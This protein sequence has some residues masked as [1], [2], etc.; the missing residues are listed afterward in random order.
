MTQEA[1]EKSAAVP[2]AP[3]TVADSNQAAWEIA[4]RAPARDLQKIW[5]SISK[6]LAFAPEFAE[7]AWYSIP[8]KDKDGK[9][10]PVEG[11]GIRGAELI[12]R[13]WGHC[14]SGGGIKE[15]HGDKVI[16]RGIFYDHKTNTQFY[17][18]TIVSKYQVSSKGTTYR[19]QG[20]H[21]DNAIQS[22]VSKAQ[23][24]AALEGVPPV[25]KEKF[26]ALVK[27]LTLN[28]KG[29]E[30]KPEELKA[31]LEKARKNF[32]TKF[33]ITEQQY[34]SYI[35]G[36]SAETDEDLLAHLKGLWSA[37]K[38]GEE[39]VA[40]VFGTETPEGKPVMSRPQEVNPDE[41]PGV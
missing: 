41:L 27:K 31:D 10:V 18:E 21:W 13:Y 39:T 19:L 20:K 1:P 6:E 16:A 22:A 38:S 17:K 7:D 36:L 9:I 2:A 35:S 5:D 29:V 34:D 4:N 23:R 32:I 3:L 28:S 12:T 25:I 26:F 14:A 24:N 37:L 11:I 15:D 40:N 33:K 8:Y 30:R